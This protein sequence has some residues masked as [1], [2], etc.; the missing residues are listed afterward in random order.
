MGQ[1]HNRDILT[2]QLTSA[3]AVKR[4]FEFLHNDAFGE[5]I[6]RLERSKLFQLFLVC[7]FFRE[8]CLQLLTHTAIYFSSD[9]TLNC[10]LY[11]IYSHYRIFGYQH[12][13]PHVLPVIPGQLSQHEKIE[14]FYTL[15]LNSFEHLPQWIHLK[16]VHFLIIQWTLRQ[17]IL[18]A[19]NIYD[20]DSPCLKFLKSHEFSNLKALEFE[21]IPVS[22]KLLKTI[23]KRFKLKR[24]N[25]I[26]CSFVYK[27]IDLRSFSS[28]QMLRISSKFETKFVVPIGLICCVI[29]YEKTETKEST[30]I[31]LKKKIVVRQLNAHQWSIS[32]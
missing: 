22:D 6:F 25:L 8:K 31:S 17:K 15:I 3:L 29:H 13:I 20:I 28:L 16:D 32:Q 26:S 2:C 1:T 27:T 19:F 30:S 14:R 24:L 4:G 21:G 5:V 7:K 11:E 9:S 10:D 23:S 12:S 18:A